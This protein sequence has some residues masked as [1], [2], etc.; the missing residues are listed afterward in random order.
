MPGRL[1]GFVVM[2][3]SEDVRRWTAADIPDQHGRTAIVTGAN[4]GLGFETA[5]MLAERGATVV[6][7]C[8]DTVK[9]ADAVD[10]IRA[11]VPSA[12]LSIVALDLARLES[13][14]GAAEEIRAVHDR[15]DLLINN[16]GTANARCVQTADGYESTF[17][18]NH[19]GPFA[20]TGLL[21]DRIQAVTGAR[22]VTVSSVSHVAGAVDIDDLHFAHRRYRTLAAYAQSKLA[23]LL[24]T[25]E[26]HR[27][28]KAAGASAI[29]VAAHP[30]RQPP[31]SIATWVRA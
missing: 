12:D 30:V 18:T 6:L 20:L 13:V 31:I 9:A 14:R 7:A 24:F 27:R 19:L 25:F 29:A 28:L 4:Q 1:E 2:G 5:R 17:A 3:G 15:I 22:I 16:A 26:L 11:T 10:R 23:N 21:L 8:R